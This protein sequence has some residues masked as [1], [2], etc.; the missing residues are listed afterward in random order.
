MAVPD[1]SNLQVSSTVA[2]I[3]ADLVEWAVW[4]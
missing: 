1:C 2:W 4:A 3:R